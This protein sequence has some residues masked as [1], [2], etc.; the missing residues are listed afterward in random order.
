MT[1]AARL[2]RTCLSQSFNAFDTIAAPR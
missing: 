1:M 2:R